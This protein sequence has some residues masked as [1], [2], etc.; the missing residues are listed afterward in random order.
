MLYKVFMGKEVKVLL[1]AQL[2]DN[3]FGESRG[4]NEH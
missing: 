1:E 4:R 2:E 3:V